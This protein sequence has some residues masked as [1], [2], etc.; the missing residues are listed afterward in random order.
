IEAVL[1]SVFQLIVIVVFVSFC[2][3]RCT[4]LGCVSWAMTINILLTIGNK[5]LIIKIRVIILVFIFMLETD[6]LC[7]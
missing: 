3:D 7:I 2:H 6:K 4:Y 5:K 1:T